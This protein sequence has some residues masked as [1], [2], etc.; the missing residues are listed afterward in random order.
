[1]RVGVKPWLLAFVLIAGCGGDSKP[2]LPTIMTPPMSV[3]V[4]VGQTATFTVAASGNGSIT[5][6]WLR[7]GQLIAGANTTTFVTGSTAITDNGASFQ[8][9]VTNEAGSITSEAAIL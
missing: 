7:D 3:T 5:Y 2:Q 4:E 8:V 9:S 6:Q 1:M